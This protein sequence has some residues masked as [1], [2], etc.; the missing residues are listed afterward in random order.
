MK[1]DPAVR[2]LSRFATRQVVLAVI[3]V[4]FA[5]AALAMLAEALNG[6]G[7]TVYLAEIQPSSGGAA[8]V[9]SLVVS[10]Y[11]SASAQ[12]EYATLQFQFSNFDNGY[13]G[14]YN[15][16]TTDDSPATPVA[17]EVEAS[18]PIIDAMVSAGAPKDGVALVVSESFVAN[19][20]GAPD[21][22]GFRLDVILPSPTLET[23]LA[24]VN[25]AGQTGSEGG[26]RMVQ[27]GVAYGLA[28]CGPLRTA[29]WEAAVADARARAA[30]QAAM[31]G[32]ETGDLVFS[33]ET[34]LGDARALVE[35]SAR[36]G[37]C[38]ASNE[39]TQ[40]EIYGQGSASISVPPFDPVAP[41]ETRAY[42]QVTLGFEI[43][44]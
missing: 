34:I 3:V 38:S 6:G 37:G 14:T 32:V 18:N 2:S 36:N 12:A 23:V 13:M 20:Y 10:G 29:A 24:I 5:M 33:N 31:L 42:A 27:S 17:V 9:P 15:N 28:D 25:A 16:S 11:G 7:G 43:M 19:P 35:S 8:G 40:L 4:I 1:V 39:A 30:E 22:I 44:D 41:P 26:Y 21:A